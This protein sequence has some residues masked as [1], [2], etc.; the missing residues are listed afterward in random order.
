MNC[1]LIAPHPLTKFAL[2]MQLHRRFININVIEFQNIDEVVNAG[3]KSDLIIIDHINN[4]DTKF[5]FLFSYLRRFQSDSK[6]IILTESNSHF[7]NEN[8]HLMRA[9]ASIAKTESIDDIFSKINELMGIEET[10]LNLP[11][12]IKLTKRQKQIYFLIEDGLSNSDIAEKLQISENTVK[13]HLWRLF[14]KLN[15][16][17]RT[18][19]IFLLKNSNLL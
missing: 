4:L 7:I 17:S 10:Q 1:I 12:S 5:V 13:V 9:D 15:I 11:L 16:K 8:S 14:K 18:Q 6:I 2:S 3:A 19:L